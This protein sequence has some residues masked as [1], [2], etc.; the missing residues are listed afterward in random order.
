MLIEVCVACLVR[1]DALIQVFPGI[2]IEVTVAPVEYARIQCHEITE[3]TSKVMQI[4]HTPSRR[5]TC[6]MQELLHIFLCPLLE[7]ADAYM[8]DINCA[9]IPESG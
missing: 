2:T 1:L 8:I 3:M 4:R 5:G 9:N 6:V 7:I